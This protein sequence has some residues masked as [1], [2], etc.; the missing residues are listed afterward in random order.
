M[1]IELTGGVGSGKSTALRILSEEYGADVIGTD[2]T[3]KKLEKK[4][5]SG[6]LGLLEAFGSGI[7][8]EDGEIDRAG[9][10]AR[11]FSDEKALETVNR[12]IHPL[13]WA[14]I[15]RRIG[16]WREQSA[17]R[18]DGPEPVLVVETALPD[19]KTGDIYDEVWYVY[20]L[21]EVRIARL[22]E[23]RGY[24]REKCL[25]VMKRQP[26]DREFREMADRVLDNSGGE[27]ELKRQIGEILGK[28][29]TAS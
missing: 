27:E 11:I 12:I 26:S 15:H 18:P 7:L 14:E 4:G 8:D 24:S 9:L 16:R 20:T 28:G 29:R 13:V 22:M 2:Q 19:K 5:K 17:S 25:S 3:A 1:V 23:S 21:D 6:Y 10:A